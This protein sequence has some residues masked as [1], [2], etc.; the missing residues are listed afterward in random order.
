MA[1]SKLTRARSNCYKDGDYDGN[2]YGG[3]HH[4][5]AHYI[6]RSQMGMDLRMNLCK[7]R[8]YGI[9]Q[10]HENMK[11]F[12]GPPTRSTARK[13]EEENEE[14]GAL[15]GGNFKIIRGRHWIEKMKI[16]EAPNIP[17]VNNASRES[18]RNKL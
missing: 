13:L 6:Y 5:D 14:M 2:A 11:I 15:L 18:E 16:K 17:N 4:R 12:Q 9:T 3:S 7:E 10:E 1:Y 8:G